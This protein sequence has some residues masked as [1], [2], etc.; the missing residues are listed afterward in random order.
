[1]ANQNPDEFFNNN[2]NNGN[3][4]QQPGKFNFGQANF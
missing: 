4:H 1:M 3:Q 2:N